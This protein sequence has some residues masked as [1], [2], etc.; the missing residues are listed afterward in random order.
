MSNRS[1]A[2]RG[3]APFVLVLA[4]ACSDRNP[5]APGPVPPVD[6][7]RAKLE[8]RVDVAQ[9]EMSCASASTAGGARA[10]VIGGQGVFVKLASSGTAYDGGTQILSSSVTV[11]NLLQQ[12]LGTDGVTTGGVQVFFESGPVVTSGTG[13]V[14]VAN[15]DGTGTFTS[16]VQ[17]YFLYGQ[18]LSPF[19]ISTAKVWQFNV[20][21]TVVS[22]VFTLYVNAQVTNAGPQVLRGPVWDGSVSSDWFVAGNWEGD[23]IPTPTSNATIP[24]LSQLAGGANM[25]VIPADSGDV[26][27]ANLLVG[28]G[29]TLGL[30]GNTLTVS[31]NVDAMGTVSG[32]TLLMSGAGGLLRGN[33]DAA[34]LS[35]GISL[36][37]AAKATGAVSVTGSLAVRDQALSISV[38]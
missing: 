17:P 5:V 25:P 31:G 20:P 10:T 36:Q 11:Q 30:G 23:S 38:P 12:T 24:A 3:L 18:A 35:G 6:A 26:T 34:V 14:T 19:Q 15:P 27:V 9:A 4:A 16:G 33:V 21:S 29:S 7:A 28:T 1:R 2:L 13:A 37:G 8:C 22:F 32:G